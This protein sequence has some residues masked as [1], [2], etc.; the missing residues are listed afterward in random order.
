MKKDSRKKQPG[1]RFFEWLR[2]GTEALHRGELDK[3]IRF[4]ERASRLNPANPDAALNLAGAYILS[5]KFAQAVAVLEPLSEQ[6]PHNPMVWTNLG[7]AYLGNPILA[8]DEDH[9][10][11]IT[12]F[13][14][15]LELDP[16]APN[17]AYNL[18]LVHLDRQENERALYWFRRAVQANPADR[19]AHRFI[20]RLS[21]EGKDKGD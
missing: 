10:R 21:E 17:V 14:R 2:Q 11:A 20:D 12:A 4:L 3:A 6:E 15:A 5:K 9:Q 13:E 19:D 8:K 1:D 18:G 7:A 16:G